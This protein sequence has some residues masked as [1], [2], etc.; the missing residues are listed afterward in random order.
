VLLTDGNETQGSALEAAE[1][2][3]AAGVAIYSVPVGRVDPGE[4]LLQQMSAP[5]EVKQ[6]E[7]FVIHIGAWSAGERAGRLSLYRDGTFVGSR[8]VHLKQGRNVFSYRESLDAAGFHVYQARVEAPGD[9][10]EE[11]N[12]AVAVVAVRGRPRV[13]YLE[14][15]REQGRHLTEALKAQGMRVEQVALDG[16]PRALAALAEYDALILSN[17]SALRLTKPQMEAVRSYV[18]DQGGGL[19]MLGGEESFGVGGYYR[20]PIEEA[21][22]VTME[23]RQKIEVPSLAVVL[24]IDR[25]GSME[26]AVGRSTRLDLAKEA[27]QLAV[28]LLDERQ[29]VG[30][31]AFDTAWTWVVPIGPAKDKA[32][33]LREIAS[34]SAGGGT[35]M[36]PALKESYEALYD[37]E[38]LLKHIIV[39]SDGESSDADFVG[40]VRRM[41]RDRIT[42][43]SVAISSEAGVALMREVSRWGRGR[44]YYTEDAYSVPR[45][46]TMETQ[47]AGKASLIEQPFRPAV[48]AGYH[49]IMREVDWARVPPLGGYV[50][51][52]PKR[53]AETLL[54]SRQQDPVLAVW[55][56]GVGR[57]AAFTSDAKARWGVLWLKWDLYG[58]FFSQMVRWVLR[59]G[60]PGEVAAAVRAEAGRGEVLLEAA[61][62]RGEFINFLDAEAGVVFPDARR[63]AFPLV[64]S[65]PGRYRGVFPAGSQGAYLIGISQ[66][67][68]ERP[69]GS[70]VLSLV[71][72]N[73]PELRALSVN[74]RLLSDLGKRTGGG[75]LRDVAESFQVNRRPGSSNVETWPWALLLALAV[76]LADLAVRGSTKLATAASAGLSAGGSAGPPMASRREGVAGR[77]GR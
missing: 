7:P 11:N 70:Q 55:R 6:G 77:E 14:K 39:L 71:V 49:E 53:T 26:T 44:Y 75:V 72:P 1:E 41:A 4:V 18:R 51:T 37:R 43:S 42:L 66:R 40:L 57:A 34:I 58:K 33:I 23:S 52:T 60:G 59:S 68:G 50:A 35:E 62:Q 67:R 17:V 73:S 24:L 16:I 32:A 74:E 9:V 25:S 69:V 19:L 46:F 63:S 65:G 56:Y 10:V 21:L 27:A 29:E 36:F 13:L 8:S 61:N 64:Q 31:I 54:V 2:A 48:R 22:P 76:L 47:L 30:I 3:R 28:E 12:R 5:Q 45:I 38:A 15:D 20:T